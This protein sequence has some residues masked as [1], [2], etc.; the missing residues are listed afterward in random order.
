MFAVTFFFC[1]CY[2]HIENLQIQVQ[3]ILILV[4]DK[5]I[6]FRSKIVIYVLC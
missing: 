5:F 6:N 4:L 3:R 1:I 2:F